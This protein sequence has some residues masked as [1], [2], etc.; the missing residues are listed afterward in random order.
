M[1]RNLDHRVE[2]LFPIEDEDVFAQIKRDI[3]IYWS[4]TVKSRR[5]GSDGAYHRISGENINAQELLIDYDFDVE[6]E[7]RAA[8]NEDK[9]IYHAELEEGYEDGMSDDYGD[10]SGYGEYH[11][12]ADDEE[13][14]EISDVA[15]PGGRYGEYSYK[16]E[17][18]YIDFDD[19]D[20]DDDDGGVR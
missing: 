12:S 14:D 13:D 15:A 4:D 20:D 5:L 10:T 7:A 6:E 3:D 17:Y 11:D 19:E 9:I 2:L 18:G 8:Y 1:T 16:Y